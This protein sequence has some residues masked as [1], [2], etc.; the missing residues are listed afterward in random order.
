VRCEENKFAEG[1]KQRN[2]LP[3]TVSMRVAWSPVYKYLLPDGHR[4]PMIKY[5]L[6][7]EQLLYEGTLKESDLFH[8]GLL[9]PTDALLT[10]TPEYWQKMN[11]VRLS[12]QEERLIGFPINEAFV[13]RGRH[14]SQ[15][16][17]EG[18]IS[19]LT[20]GIAL[21]MAGGTHHAFA[22]HGEGYCCFNDQA[23]AANYLLMH[24]LAKRILVVDLDV[25]QGNGT[26]HIFKENS[27]VFTFSMHGAKNYPLRKE[28]SSLDI[29]LVDGIDDQGYLTILKETLPRLIDDIEPDFIFYQAGV[30][31]LETDRLGRLKVTREGCL[32]R[33]RFVLQTCKT[34]RIPLQVSMGGGYS[35]RIADIIEGHANT[36]RAASEI[37][38]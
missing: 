12:A 19:A 30:D 15:G 32:E 11:E 29:G 8:P 23:V 38:S 5:E 13:V 2:C 4:F 3:V 33:D 1:A 34:H 6:L 35:L 25:H 27:G 16:T 24:G 22:D 21:N 7:P 17:I 26:A 14:I 18:A 28:Q 10:H 36:F 31:I 20:D 37:F 9:S